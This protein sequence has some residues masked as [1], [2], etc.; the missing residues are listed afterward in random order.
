MKPVN[1]SSQVR[2]PSASIDAAA[3]FNILLIALMFTL[4]GSRFIVAPGLSLELDSLPAADVSGGALTDADI[5]VL[6]AK[7]N[8]MLIYDGAIYNIA[9][10]AKK[11]ESS[12]AARKNAVLL[13]KADKNVD[14]Q[15]LVDIS[16]AAKKGGFERIQIAAKASN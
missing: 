13:V 6:S 10:F 12:K 14:A 4:L 5:C 1:V 9:T 11:M 7:G 15:T 2:R 16:L 3:L 8:S